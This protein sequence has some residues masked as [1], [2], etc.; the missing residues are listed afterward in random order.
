MS[1]IPARCPFKAGDR[2]QMHGY[3]GAKCAPRDHARTGFRGVVEGCI[4]GTILT[5]TT[6]A[7]RPWAEQWGHL[8]PDGT[9]NRSAAQCNCC[10][11]AERAGAAS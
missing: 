10:P 2:V 5:G 9:P 6:D 7:G 8:D 4:G 11:A 3:P 1:P